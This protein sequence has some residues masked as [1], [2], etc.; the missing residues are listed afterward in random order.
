MRQLYYTL[1]TLL[2][3]KGSSFTKL[4]S[5]TLGLTA[6][7]LLFSQIAYELDYESC[8]PE[9]DILAIVRGH[10]YNTATGE[11]MGDEGNNSYDY[12][13]YDVMAPTLAR[14]MKQWIESGTTINSALA[15]QKTF[16]ENRW[17][18]N[19]EYLLVDTCFFRT[20]GI[21][22]LRGNPQELIRPDAAFVSQHF[23][24]ETFGDADPI[25][26]ILTLDK[27]DTLTVRGIYSDM[28]HN[29][30][31]R[32]DFVTSIHRD[33]GYYG[34]NG[35]NGNDVFFS[36]LRLRQATDVDAINANLQRI[37]QQYTLTEYDGW[38]ADYDVIPLRKMHTDNP[39]TRQR[40][41][42][43]GF[44]G[45]ALFFV[46]AMNYILVAIASLSRRAKAVGVYKCSGAGA[47]SIFSL[48][49]METGMYVVGASILSAALIY[50]CSGYVENV[51]E[52]KPAD[53]FTWQ[54][55][56]V[57]VLTAVLLIFVAG[58]IP[59]QMYARIPVSQ[60]FR[61]YTDGKRGWKS[62]LLAVQFAGV[63][64]VLGLLI[65][66]ILQ[67]GM[68]TG[69]DMG[70]RLPGLV[71]AE[72]WVG[73]E[74]GES[75]CDYLRRQPY[76]EGVTSASNGVIGQY[77]TQGL[78]GNDGKRISV[79]NF[80][81][82]TRDYPEVMGMEII[83][84]RGLQNEGDLLVNEEV[85]RRMKWTDGAVGKRL[86]QVP[87]KWGTIVGVFRDV[88]NQGFNSEQQTIVLVRHDVYH[89]FNVRLRE[90]YDENLTRLNAFVEETFPHIA[91]RFVPVTDIVKEMYGDV[92]R[93]RNAVYL[94]SG[95]ILLI[96]LVGLTGYVTD[97]TQRR[98][99][100]I[101]IRKVNGAEVKDILI[102]LSRGILRVAIPSVVIGTA[103]AWFTGRFWLEQFI[104]QANVSP[105]L[106]VGLCLLLMLLVVIVVVCKA[107]RIA[108]EN[109]VVSIK[110][111]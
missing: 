19:A 52:V 3:G 43:L 101:A 53:L 107:W 71:Q 35:W 70:I 78:M 104:E 103:V 88:R 74:A 28:P 23:A 108:N 36:I 27:K 96:V 89:A 86:N 66:T 55:M 9:A 111:E 47:G 109:P 69:R 51:F 34:G 65:V 48:F 58:V 17:L 84:G 79:L 105:W 82:V 16:Y 61:R 102:L 21:E 68:L 64:F 98:S 24:R 33:G 38:K 31:L 5:L 20:T 18:E 72:S 73:N 1:Q 56:W 26:K 46:A 99:K 42:I 30:I 93:F 90:P 25:G 41:L 60:L 39:D 44:L 15:N 106:F 95:F 37:I 14:D 32:H 10:N 77:W 7:I 80:N 45:F 11:T 83:E 85:V 4:L 13:V 97:E 40:L 12:T 8:Y 91:L 57:P 67:Y 22:V 87:A 94:A 59:G 29:S 100:E 62:G 92:F 110:S 76:I 63:S 6:G 50:L 54:L 75:L 2:R 81:Y 49:L